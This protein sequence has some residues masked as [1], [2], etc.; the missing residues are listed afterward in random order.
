[1]NRFVFQR[2]QT[3]TGEI[4]VAH[5][6]SMRRSGFLQMIADFP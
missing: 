1:L 4:G 2:Q 5:R 6:E 3:M